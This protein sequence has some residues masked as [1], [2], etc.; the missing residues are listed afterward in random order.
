MIDNSFF[1]D[2]AQE[3]A[4]KLL[5]KVLYAWDR[6]MWLSA[7]IIETE[8]YY[9][10]DK[11][12]HASLGFTQKRKALFMP[13]GTIYMYYARGA[14]S[15]N[16]SCRG[17]GNAVLIKSAYPYQDAE[18]DPNM[19]ARMQENNPNKNHSAP[20]P[21]NKLCSGQTLLC[22]SLNL[23]VPHWDAQQFNEKK[24]YIA[25]RHYQPEGI[26][27]ASRLGIPLG[28]DEHLPYRFILQ[29]FAQHSTK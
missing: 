15:L 22:K 20:R 25:D 27:T 14:D 6:D 28:R 13:P 7:M 8:A 5:G 21:I 3:V 4:K 9:L 11:A 10:E 24:F 16:I 18:S 29:E 12:S 1:N 2:D 17:E 26:I 23:K 19:I